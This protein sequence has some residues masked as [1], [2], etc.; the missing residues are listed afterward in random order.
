MGNIM[1]VNLSLTR[2]SLVRD[3]PDLDETLKEK[4]T[5]DNESDREA[6]AAIAER[7]TQESQ[8]PSFSL[9]LQYLQ[10]D[11]LHEMEK[12]Q[13][14][15]MTYIAFFELRASSV[16]CTSSCLEVESTSKL[17]EICHNLEIDEGIQ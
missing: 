17:L 2:F 5:L 4:D 14:R 8:I 9:I 15:L 6:L 3:D 7:S 16:P 12:I 11:N 1:C 13:K 10:N